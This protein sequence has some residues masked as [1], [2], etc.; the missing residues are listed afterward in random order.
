MD[1]VLSTWMGQVLAQQATLGIGIPQSTPY[2]TIN[3]VCSSS[4]KTIMMA[5]ISHYSLGGPRDHGSR[6]N[7]Y[8]NY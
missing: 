3:K 5:P 7:P 4:L 1:N 6:W 2:K 8:G